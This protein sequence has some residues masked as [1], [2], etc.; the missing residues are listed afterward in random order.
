[1]AGNAAGRRDVT[2]AND[3]RRF[4]RRETN[5]EGRITWGERRFAQCIVRDISVGGAMVV[6]REPTWLPY[7]FM[8]EIPAS[9]FKTRCEIRH[10]NELRFGVEFVGLPAV[11]GAHSERGAPIA[12]VAPAHGQVTPRCSMA[13]LRALVQRQ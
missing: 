2:A 6:L 13:E 9:G 3:R 8:L 5:W 12:R 11:T 7:S 1:M 4:G 10:Q